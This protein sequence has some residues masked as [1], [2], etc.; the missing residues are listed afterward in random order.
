MR[1]AIS[2]WASS[3]VIGVMMASQVMAAA[4]PRQVAEVD[5]FLRTHPQVAKRLAADPKL[6]DDPDFLAKH[7]A[8][9]RFL[10]V[11]PD[12]RELIP[13]ASQRYA[14]RSSDAAKAGGRTTP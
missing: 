5:H 2:I 10:I 6:V 7:P 8:L 1:R 4:R 11:N 13:S 12:A 9:K 14:G 3:I